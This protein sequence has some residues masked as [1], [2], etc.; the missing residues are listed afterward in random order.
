MMGLNWR[1]EDSS[2]RSILSDQLELWFL[3]E[4]GKTERLK[5]G[6]TKILSK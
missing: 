5:N 2:R 6:K 3:N 4:D 1:I